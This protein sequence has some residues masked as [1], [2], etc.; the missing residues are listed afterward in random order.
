MHFCIFAS[1]MFFYFYI[2]IY[3]VVSRLRK[4]DP[5]PD[6]ATKSKPYS[7]FHI[8]LVLIGLP[9]ADFLSFGVEWGA[10][11]SLP[12]PLLNPFWYHCCKKLAIW[13]TNFQ[14]PL[15][16]PLASCG[17]HLG[18]ILVLPKGCLFQ[19]L[20]YTFLLRFVSA[21]FWRLA[22]RSRPCTRSL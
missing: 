20:V 1:F 16:P 6:R 8:T 2:Y 11:A 4:V 14:R 3:N 13:V 7:R 18:S 5:P 15:T 21:S 22:W 12:R 10:C 9:L 19:L 17:Y